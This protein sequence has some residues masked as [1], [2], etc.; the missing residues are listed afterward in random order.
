MTSGERALRVSE[1]VYRALLV[2]YHKEFR[3]VTGHR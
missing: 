1:R 3:R 2:A